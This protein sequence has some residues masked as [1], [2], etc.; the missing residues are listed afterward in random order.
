VL[1]STGKKKVERA[2]PP[3]PE[4]AIDSTKEDVEWTKRRAQKARG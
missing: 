2:T 4:Q 3:L 1:A